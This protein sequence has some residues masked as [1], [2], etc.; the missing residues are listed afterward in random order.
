MNV[1]WFFKS[2]NVF[3]LQIK[4]LEVAEKHLMFVFHLRKVLFLFGTYFELSILTWRYGVW[5]EAEEGILDSL[6]AFHASLVKT[7]AS[8]E[9]Y[10][11]SGKGRW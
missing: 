2:L 9:I 6:L 4:L 3:L 5:V 11:S 7:I 1:D 10:A 8:S